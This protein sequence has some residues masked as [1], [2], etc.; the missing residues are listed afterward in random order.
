MKRWILLLASCLAARG[1]DIITTTITFDREIARMFYSRCV[2]CHHEGGPAFSLMT[3]K[4][5]RPWA[6]AIKEEVL[7]RRMPP[8]GAV[9][10]FGDFRNDQALTPE[11]MELITNWAQ[12]GAPEGEEKDLPDPPKFTT[13]PLAAHRHGELTM[14]GDLQLPRP[15]V[16]DGLWPQKLPDHTVVRITAELP[17][18][19]VEPLL[20][21]DDYKPLYAHVFLFRK[22]L[23]LPAK[24]MIRG[25]PAGSKVSLLPRGK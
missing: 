14:N 10:G 24:T 12:G 22:P 20:W 18:G 3:Y 6:E 9:K 4:E 25:V 2:S 15:F 7:T 1:H 13:N 19:T 8:W 5:A 11:Q 17:D 23:E 21:M 16:L